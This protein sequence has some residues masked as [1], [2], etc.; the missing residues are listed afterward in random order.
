MHD[1]LLDAWPPR[2]EDVTEGSP[3]TSPRPDPL[4]MLFEGV[5]EPVIV[6][7]DEELPLQRAPSGRLGLYVLLALLVVLALI[8]LALLLG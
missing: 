7:E 1:E 8:R 5:P 6:S 3:K 4:S 2:R